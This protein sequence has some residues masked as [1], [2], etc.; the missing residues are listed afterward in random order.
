MEIPAPP[1]LAPPPSL[2]EQIRHSIIRRLGGIVPVVQ[3]PTTQVIV[4]DNPLLTMIPNIQFFDRGFNADA[5]ATASDVEGDFLLERDVLPLENQFDLVLS[6][7]TLE[8]VSDPFTFC[9][10]LVRVAR[11]GGHIFLATVFAWEYHPSPEDYFRF[12]PT[13][14]IESFANSGAD[15]LEIRLG[16]RPDQHLHPPAQ[17]GP[18][19]LKPHP[20]HTPCAKPSSSGS[21][22]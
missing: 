6:F 17:T 19:W 21:P 12:S 15:V 13:G 7:D 18:S 1:P 9:R 10:N 8:H 14:L 3:P 2:G 5:I 20:F 22:C 16:H 4:S 11:P